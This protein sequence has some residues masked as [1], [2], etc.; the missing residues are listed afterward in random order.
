VSYEVCIDTTDNEECD[1]TWSSAGGV[2]SK[3]EAAIDAGLK[4]VMVPKSNM[5]DIIISKEKLSK[6]NVI[7]VETIQE[8]LGQALSWKN[9]ENVLKQIK[10]KG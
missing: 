2:T 8:V 5:Q 10:K 4:Y 6:I 7:P 1:S 9:K 3:V